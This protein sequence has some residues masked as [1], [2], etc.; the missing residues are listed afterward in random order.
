MNDRAANPSQ[1]QS[2]L[3]YPLE[4]DPDLVLTYLKTTLSRLETECMN[5][6]LAVEQ[7]GNIFFIQTGI[8]P[9]AMIRTVLE[10]GVRYPE[11]FFKGLELLRNLE[12]NLAKVKLN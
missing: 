5:S 10:I 6:F 1:N 3:S 4:N 2:S 7:P 9:E 8:S 12:R 11:E